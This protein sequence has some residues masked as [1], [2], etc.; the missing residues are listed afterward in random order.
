VCTGTVLIITVRTK[1]R[2]VSGGPRGALRVLFAYVSI[3]GG[4]TLIVRRGVSGAV[5]RALRRAAPVKVRVITALRESGAA[6]RTQS[7]VRLLRTR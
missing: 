7:A 4:S 1:F 3:P 6:G 2:P 5:A